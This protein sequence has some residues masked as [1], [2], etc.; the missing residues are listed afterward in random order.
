MRVFLGVAL[1]Q[2]DYRHAGAWRPS[3]FN[4]PRVVNFNGGIDVSHSRFLSKALS[5][6]REINF[7]LRNEMLSA[8]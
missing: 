4:N 5:F 1:G 3:T 7:C 2:G 8:Q 6:V